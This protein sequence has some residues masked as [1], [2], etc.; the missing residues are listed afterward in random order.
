LGKP[1]EG[2]LCDLWS[3]IQNI[4]NS[5]GGSG[6]GVGSAIAPNGV[7]IGPGVSPNGDTGTAPNGTP[8]GPGV[9]PNGSPTSPPPGI[10]PNGV[11]IIYT[12]SIMLCPYIGWVDEVEL[13][14][15]WNQVQGLSG[16]ITTLIALVEQVIA[17]GNGRLR[18]DVGNGLAPL[19]SITSSPTTPDPHGPM[20]T[21]ET[22]IIAA[23][24]ESKDAISPCCYPPNNCDDSI[25]NS[26]A[27]LIGDYHQQ[28]INTNSITLSFYNA[29]T[30]GCSQLTTLDNTCGDPIPP[31]STTTPVPTTTITTP[32][33]CCPEFPA[34]HDCKELCALAGQIGNLEEN[35]AAI[36][37]ALQGSRLRMRHARSAPDLYIEGNLL[38]NLKEA[39][40]LIEGCLDFNICN[41]SH[42]SQISHTLGNIGELF[43]TRSL[44]N[45]TDNFTDNLMNIFKQID[46]SLNK[47]RA[48]TGP[49]LPCPPWIL[50]LGL[51]DTLT[52][53]L[54]L[55]STP[56]D[57]IP[58]GRRK[59]RADCTE[60][61]SL[62]D[63]LT[64]SDLLGGA[65]SAAWDDLFA[66]M[67]ELHSCST[68][69]IVEALQNKIQQH[70]QKMIQI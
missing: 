3:D 69:A 49:H 47:S 33:D 28:I 41:G 55:A 14:I 48:G 32:S 24:T 70:Y 37:A 65:H 34:Q 1:N 51:H 11:F 15:L 26:T 44:T 39:Y 12:T 40:V 67:M 63:R 5:G 46:Y 16:S 21:L 20:T 45:L 7:A 8:L 30:A 56:G 38:E 2:I 61:A 42:A 9:N 4:T 54:C 36:I 29:Y 19:L 13:C 27:A 50:D 22:N 64:S 62:L 35:L 57:P 17:A 25:I 52:A 6:S 68:P 60:Y 53:S 23:L 10:A 18:R 59:R 43:V 58:T 31:T 66:R